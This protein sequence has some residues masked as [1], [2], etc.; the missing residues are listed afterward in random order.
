MVLGRALRH[1]RSP[2]AEAS[3]GLPPAASLLAPSVRGGAAMLLIPFAVLLAAMQAIA[4]RPSLLAA[5]T[6]LLVCLPVGPEVEGGGLADL[7]SAALVAVAVGRALLTG[8]QTLSRVA[9][10]LFGAVLVALAL[11]T[12]TS[13]DSTTSLAGLIRYM[14]LFVLVPVAVTISVRDRHDIA[15]VCGALLV[16]SVFEGA[17]GTVQYLTGTGASY[18]G[19]NVRS[20]GTF[21]ATDIMAMATVVSYGMLLALGLGLAA[22]GPYRLMLLFTA[23][24]LLL[25]LAFSLSR[26]AWIATAVAIVVMLLLHSVRVAAVAGLIAAALGVILVGGFGVGSEMLGQRV[27]S[28]AESTTDP[29]QSVSDRYDLWTSAEQIWADHPVVGVGLRGFPEYR[30]SYAPLRLSSGSDTDDPTGGFTKQE[31]LSPHSMFFLLLSEQ[32]LVG[33]TAFGGLFGA[34]AVAAVARTRRAPGRM[35]RGLGLAATG[36]LIW[37]LV[38]FGYGDVG[39]QTSVLMAV[40][41]GL[42]A[43]W[44]LPPPDAVATPADYRADYRHEESHHA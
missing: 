25:P 27:A 15:L 39:G 43:R 14:Q 16:V 2:T 4:R 30:D 8:E 21:G 36:A 13:L 31:L 37:Q 12:V 34:L 19:E 18:M 24:F 44:A 17:L 40:V 26:G 7:A 23:I 28:I 3:E 35:L 6:V 42:G 9:A 38:R 5:A 11:A 1:P 33:L 10:V 22:H 29:D 41:L 20:I 32:G